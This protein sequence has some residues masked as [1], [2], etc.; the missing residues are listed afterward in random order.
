MHRGNEQDW[1]DF[2]Y[3][4]NNIVNFFFNSSHS[5]LSTEGQ[6]SD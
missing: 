6:E 3:F 4:L 1:E 2:K 5:F